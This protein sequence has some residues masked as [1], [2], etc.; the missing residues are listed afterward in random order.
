MTSPKSQLPDRDH[1]GPPE[2]CILLSQAS[3]QAFH[4]LV[5]S[6]TLTFDKVQKAVAYIGE[7][8]GGHVPRAALQGGAEIDLVF[9]RLDQ[10]FGETWPERS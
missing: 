1:H 6:F 4:W 3:V 9:K 7:G 5:K 10:P 8:K 2:Q